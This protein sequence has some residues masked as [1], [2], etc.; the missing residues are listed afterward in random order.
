MKVSNI[1][2]SFENEKRI[3]KELNHPQIIKLQQAVTF[4]DKYGLIYEIAEYGDLL[5]WTNR[6]SPISSIK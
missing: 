1:K 3:L 4:D 5:F 2:E 6:L